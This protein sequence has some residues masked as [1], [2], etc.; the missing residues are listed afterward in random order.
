MY[1]YVV[2]YN[3]ERNSIAQSIQHKNKA[4]DLLLGQQ[5][6]WGWVVGLSVAREGHLG[7]RQVGPVSPC[8][9]RLQQT[10]DNQ[11][12]YLKRDVEMF[13]RDRKISRE[14]QRYPERDVEISG[15]R[16]RNTDNLRPLHPPSTTCKSFLLP[17]LLSLPLLVSSSP[18]SEH[19]PFAQPREIKNMN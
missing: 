12:K 10:Y 3:G 1:M 19:A 14:M 7:S 11:Y 2:I 6:L 17:L 9:L 15:E 4:S 13:E 16:C 18:S 8:Y 5:V